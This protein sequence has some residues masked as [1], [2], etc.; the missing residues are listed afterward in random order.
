MKLV[1]CLDCKHFHS[2][3]RTATSMCSCGHTYFCVHSWIT[4]PSKNPNIRYAKAVKSSKVV[5]VYGNCRVFYLSDKDLADM[6]PG[7]IIR[8]QLMKE[9]HPNIHRANKSEILFKDQPD[10]IDKENQNND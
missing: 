6:Q 3:E 1:Q 10:L 5:W 9:P 2:I 7:G 4:T 8:L